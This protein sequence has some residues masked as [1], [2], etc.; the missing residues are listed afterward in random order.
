M[1]AVEMV[2]RSVNEV[3]DV[4]PVRDGR[5]PAAGVVLRGALDGGAR[6]GVP[7]VHLEDVLRDA[8]GRGRVE[9]AVVEIIGVIAMTDDTMTTARP[10]LVRM[11]LLP[12]HDET[13]SSKRSIVRPAVP[14]QA[15]QE[16]T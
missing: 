3:V 8:F 9:M 7:P 16:A 6:C 10:V 11:L 15:A 13:P 14:G 2:E 1:I 5:M 12:A 4:V